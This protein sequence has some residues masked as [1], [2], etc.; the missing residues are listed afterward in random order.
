MSSEKLQIVEKFSSE[1][2][3]VKLAHSTLFWC[4]PGA[5]PLENAARS[6][7]KTKLF[8]LLHGFSIKLLGFPTCKESMEGLNYR[9]VRPTLL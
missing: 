7:G 5:E 8:F 9:P 6:F 3:G 2:G 1:K 4:R